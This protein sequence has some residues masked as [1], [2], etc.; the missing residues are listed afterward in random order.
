MKNRFN[1]FKIWNYQRNDNKNSL[2]MEY[3]KTFFHTY[4]NLYGDQIY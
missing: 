2:K 1:T 3:Q 4:L